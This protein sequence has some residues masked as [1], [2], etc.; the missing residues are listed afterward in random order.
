VSDRDAFLCARRVA[1]VEGI[2]IGGSGGMAVQAA[3][4]VASELTP[5]KTVL[6]ILPDGGR[7]YLSKVFDDDWMRSH[8]LLDRP[9]LPP[10]VADLMAAKS[11]DS[12]DVPSIVTIAADVP[13]SEAI[14]LLQRYGISQ[15]PVRG[16]G[17][18]DDEP[19]VSG[20]IGSIEERTLLDRVF[21]EGGEVLARPVE[22]LMSPPL[23]TVD[24]LVQLDDVY[25]ALQSNPALVVV[26]EHHQAV[27]VL[28]RTD[29]LEF[30]SHR[31]A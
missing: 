3:L 12:P 31:R 18:A 24:V 1:A 2:L 28:T 7:P 21:R 20:L 27:G 19:S 4:D 17:V 5:D 29:L 16:A 11:S 10:T 30:L 13:G 6:V 22:Q 14:D 23:E 9:G 15:L 25:G 8:G 26:D